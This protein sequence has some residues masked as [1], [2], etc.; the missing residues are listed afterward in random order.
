MGVVAE[1]GDVEMKL[2]HI[3][4]TLWLACNVGAVTTQLHAAGPSWL[5][6]WN[7]FGAVLFGY[8]VRGLVYW[9]DEK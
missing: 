7:L 6:Y 3:I 1:K 5:V 2:M 9:N 8:F 4:A